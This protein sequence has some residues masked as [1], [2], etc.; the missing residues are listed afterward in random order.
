M[1]IQRKNEEKLP[2]E[3]WVVKL[4]QYYPGNIVFRVIVIDIEKRMGRMGEWFF[5]NDLW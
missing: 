4:N 3:K 1:I 2:L 5:E